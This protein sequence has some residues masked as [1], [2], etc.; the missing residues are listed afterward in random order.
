MDC[1]IGLNPVVLDFFMLKQASASLIKITGKLALLDEIIRIADAL[2]D[3]A[4]A[5]AR[6]FGHLAQRDFEASEGA[7][8]I[9]RKLNLNDDR[10]SKLDF[11]L[12]NEARLSLFPDATSVRMWMDDFGPIISRNMNSVTDKCSTYSV[13]YNLGN[14]IVG[15]IFQNLAKQRV[16]Y[17]HPY[18]QQNKS[19][20]V[21]E[22]VQRNLIKV[23][24]VYYVCVC[25]DCSLLPTE[26]Y[27][28][29]L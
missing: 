11:W 29:T 28:R 1:Q 9:V 26:T 15:D 14:K 27:F 13:E 5:K 19:Q 6:L 2:P 23:I 4:C 3:S 12:K 25:C 24:C 8:E 22:M 7:E 21:L 17:H 10:L 18:F 16:I 20:M